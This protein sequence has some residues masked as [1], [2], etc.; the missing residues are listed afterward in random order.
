MK[1]LN[2][3]LK[4]PKPNKKI[5]EGLIKCENGPQRTNLRSNHVDWWLFDDADMCKDFEVV[6]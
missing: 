1:E 6:K 3:A 4:L 2:E 5:I